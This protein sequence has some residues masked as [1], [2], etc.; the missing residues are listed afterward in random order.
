MSVATQLAYLRA[1]GTA[2]SGR[3]NAPSLLGDSKAAAR[4]PRSEVAGAALNGLDALAVGDPS[5]TYLA[6]PLL[7]RRP[8]TDRANLSVEEA[9]RLSEAVTVLALRISPVFLLRP[10]QKLLEWVVRALEIGRLGRENEV[11][12]LFL[13]ALP[14]HATKQFSLLARAILGHG[15]HFKNWSWLAPVSKQLK[16]ASVEFMVSEIPAFV[17]QRVVAFATESALANIV[18]CPLSNFVSSVIARRTSCVLPSSVNADEHRRILADVL[19]GLSKLRKGLS[20]TFESSVFRQSNDVNVDENAMDVDT[21]QKEADSRAI[22]DTISAFFVALSSGAVALGPHDKNF[23]HSCMKSSIAVL[24]L[25]RIPIAVKLSAFSCFVVS[26]IASKCSVLPSDVYDALSKSQRFLQ[27]M[28][29]VR[30][31]DVSISRRHLRAVYFAYAKGAVL[32]AVKHSAD[33]EGHEDLRRLL[34]CADPNIDGEFL[35][36]V[37]FQ[38]LK[39][40]LEHFNVLDSNSPGRKIDV[41]NDGTSREQSL[42]NMQED[43][44]TLQVSMSIVADTLSPLCRGRYAANVGSAIH[45]FSS[46]LDACP[47]SHHRKRD[48]ITEGLSVALQMVSRGSADPSNFEMET[49]EPGLVI[50]LGLSLDHPEPLVRKAAIEKLSELHKE[51]KLT[52]EDRQQLAKGLLRRISVAED[53]TVVEC[54]VRSPAVLDICESGTLVNN[55]VFVL[56]KCFRDMMSSREVLNDT[57]HLATCMLDVLHACMSRQR[58]ATPLDNQ[59]FAFLLRSSFQNLL[60]LDISDVNKAVLALLS[61]LGGRADVVHHALQEQS[62]GGQETKTRPKRE[63]LATSFISSGWNE[64]APDILRQVCDIDLS[65]GLDLYSQKFRSSKDI[66]VPY[67]RASL[68]Y[69]VSIAEGG[70]NHLHAQS[71]WEDCVLSSLQALSNCSV[72]DPEILEDLSRAWNQRAI[73]RN[74]VLVDEML[75]I[76]CR[77]G[78]GISAV[79]SFVQNR[80]W[81]GSSTRDGVMSALEVLAGFAASGKD[82]FYI[83]LANAISAAFNDDEFK[84]HVALKT[85]RYASNRLRSKCSDKRSSPGLRRRAEVMKFIAYALREKGSRIVEIKWHGMDIAEYILDDF[86]VSSSHLPLPLQLSQLQMHGSKLRH[87]LRTSLQRNCED[88]PWALE[89]GIAR[90]LVGLC[91]SSEQ[92]KDTLKEFR[93]ANVLLTRYLESSNANSKAPLADDE[94]QQAEEAIALFCCRLLSARGV[95]HDDPILWDLTV[96]IKK[97]LAQLFVPSTQLSTT[98][99]SLVVGANTGQTQTMPAKRTSSS[100]ALMKVLL[101]LFAHVSELT[102]Q[103][104]MLSPTITKMQTTCAEVEAAST[105]TPAPDALLYL[106]DIASAQSSFASL[107]ETILC[108]IPVLMHEQ[109]CAGIIVRLTE[110]VSSLLGHSKRHR[111]LDSHPEVQTCDTGHGIALLEVLAKY[112]HNSSSGLTGMPAFLMSSLSTPIWSLLSTIVDTKTDGGGASFENIEH[113]LRLVVEVLRIMVETDTV[114]VSQHKEEACFEAAKSDISAALRSVWYAHDRNA[115]NVSSALLAIHRSAFAL[116]EALAVHPRM[117]VDDNIVTVLEYA[118]H[119][120]KWRGA[121]SSISGVLSALTAKGVSPVSLIPRISN[122]ALSSE[123]SDVKDVEKGMEFVADSVNTCPDRV[124]AVRLALEAVAKLDDDGMLLDGVAPVTP[125]NSMH[126]QDGLVVSKFASVSSALI[127]KCGL[128]LAEQVQVLAFVDKARIV[129]VTTA[130]LASSE[131]LM[132]LELGDASNRE[133]RPE[134]SAEQSA[135]QSVEQ[136]FIR[137]FDS[138]VAANCSPSAQEKALGIF[139]GVVP[140]TSMAKCI[141]HSITVSGSRHTS[142]ALQA[143]ANGLEATDLSHWSSQSNQNAEY[144]D[145]VQE[146]ANVLLEIICSDGGV[147]HDANNEEIVMLEVKQ[148]ALMALE[149]LVRYLGQFNTNSMRT[150]AERLRDCLESGRVQTCRSNPVVLVRKVG[151]YLASIVLCLS[152]LVEKLTTIVADVVPCLASTSVFIIG[153]AVEGSARHLSIDNS[154]RSKEDPK[155]SSIECCRRSSDG[156]AVGN[157]VGA[158]MMRAGICGIDAVLSSTPGFLGLTSLQTLATLAVRTEEV[159]LKE[160]LLKSVRLVKPSA[161]AHAIKNIL[162]A[163]DGALMSNYGTQLVATLLS[164]TCKVMSKSDVKKLSDSVSSACLQSLD[165]RSVLFTKAYADKTISKNAWSGLEDVEKQCAEAYVAL[166]LRLPESEFRIIFNRTLEWGEQSSIPEDCL[167]SLKVK[168]AEF[169]EDILRLIP[170]LVLVDFLFEG[171]RSLAA[172]Y[173]ALVL[174]KVLRIVRAPPVRMRNKGLTKFR[175]ASSRDFDKK[176]RES[177]SSSDSEWADITLLELHHHLVSKGIICLTQFLRFCSD[178]LT[179]SNAVLSNILEALLCAFDNALGRDDHDLVTRSLCAFV[180]RVVTIGSKSDSPESSRQLLCGTSRGILSRARESDASMRCRAC[181]AARRMATSAGDDYLVVLPEAMP[182]LADLIDDEDEEVEKQARLLIK[183]L[184][185]LSGEPIMDQLRS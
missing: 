83:F 65:C 125:G 110:K 68:N 147:D 6:E 72:V 77:V 148:V 87:I 116:V 9:D 66:A 88:R 176:P 84:R 64:D 182:V 156:V 97:C 85:I 181:D 58:A 28:E 183:S 67:V 129:D 149:K 122:A 74:V 99:S 47:N 107:V 127:T 162:E 50:A 140:I 167:A 94:I 2:S 14:F 141:R 42:T 4:L 157:D 55:V 63:Y 100:D 160:L 80:I 7:L 15:R 153:L 184:E 180:S 45:E 185:T 5:L 172:P 36:T 41:R 106:L 62:D 73:S 104:Q 90:S 103:T 20:G 3:V 19:G 53:R 26:F 54:A 131:F 138:L 109:S 51:S 61:V 96:N 78:G 60:P 18:N 175:K 128:A 137:L 161:I 126:I 121:S 136:S 25:K 11:D 39:K 143:L 71:A 146:V 10:T 178:E 79:M 44:N 165:R 8:R 124:H 112:D 118:G 93:W 168:T 171:L 86:T 119:A 133:I 120:Q 155:I 12:A 32:K 95:R 164:E 114:R 170:M 134:S 105:A 82:F 174:D 135:K 56:E 24:A 169:P 152:S 29:L 89:L 22:S 132:A 16:P 23:C 115:S 27:V 70:F 30:R 154:E 31:E 166:S 159:R 179:M 37:V 38:L 91:L 69:F 158:L 81:C 1:S 102:I 150:S 145:F 48:I 57:K 177:G 76:V 173:F 151:G 98:D 130:H 40:Y 59:I 92:S 35:S 111:Y 34:A 43:E 17:I 163:S 117:S 108:R 123:L 101:C 52:V 142:Q 33:E 46:L 144:S 75:K 49:K 21:E 139:M 113:I 13:A